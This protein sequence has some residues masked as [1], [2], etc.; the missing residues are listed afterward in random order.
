[1]SIYDRLALRAGDVEIAPESTSYFSAPEDHLDPNLFDGMRFRPSMRNK[2]L[3][4]LEGF[5]QQRYR[6]SE[7][8]ST[9]WLAGSGV[10]YQ[11]S[12]ARDPGDL[13]CLIGVDMVAF[14]R[15]N[16][17]FLDLSDAE[18]AD[19][20]NDEFR[21]DLMP[22][23]SNWHGYE[24]TFYV[25]QDSQ[26]IRNINPYAAYN[27]TADEWTV[28]PDPDAH[29]PE[30]ASWRSHTDADAKRA[31][32]LVAAYDRAVAQ[33]Q[34]SP[35]VGSRL[36]A[37]I[38]LRTSAQQAVDMFDEIHEGRHA[39]FGP[40]GHGYNDFANFRWQAGK[41]SGSIQALARV[42]MA[43]RGA[44]EDER[45]DLYGDSPLDP[46]RAL[47]LSALSRRNRTLPQ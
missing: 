38:T 39:A 6:N 16:P 9:V 18:I 14:R 27:L 30:D 4:L 22:F 10:S 28:H 44:E 32:V 19:N 20:F 15:S 36:N 8:W 26:D 12:A 34:A 45:V 13:D 24:L 43:L 46:R 2:I 41:Q 3:S 5:W 17:D 7:T 47:I 42:K 23:T 35:N 31:A 40:G 11:W 29:A 37:S 33:V 21:S 25:N 1:M